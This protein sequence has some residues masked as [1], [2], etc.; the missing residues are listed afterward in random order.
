MDQQQLLNGILYNRGMLLGLQQILHQ[1]LKSTLA[2]GEVHKIVK[3]KRRLR[4]H[5][6][7]LR[8]NSKQSRPLYPSLGMG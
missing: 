7:R 6:V 5:W 1:T 2:P 3:W 8:H 4:Q